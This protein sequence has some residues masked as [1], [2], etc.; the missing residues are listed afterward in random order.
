VLKLQQ[1]D[2]AASFGAAAQFCSN[3]AVLA[4][5]ATALQATKAGPRGT[6]AY[7]VNVAA[8]NHLI[9]EWEIPAS[10]LPTDIWRAG[11]WN[12]PVHTSV[13]TSGN[14]K[15]QQIAICAISS[16]NAARQTLATGAAS[17]PV[18]A[19]GVA[20]IPV[21]QSADYIPQAGDKIVIVLVG[22]RVTANAVF[23]LMSDQ[24]ILAPYGPA[25]IA[26]SK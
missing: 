17:L 26:R 5:G 18:F 22:A 2:S 12:V 6:A 14:G 9:I 16:A 23:T 4:T 15:W 13:F 21:L 8:G 25:H 20:V 11:N 3:T 1:T 10:E 7:P 24:Q 19:Q